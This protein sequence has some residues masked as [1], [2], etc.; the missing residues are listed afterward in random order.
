MDLISTEIEGMCLSAPA[1]QQII[2]TDNIPDS[3][4][5]EMDATNVMTGIMEIDLRCTHATMIFFR[6]RSRNGNRHNERQY[7]RAYNRDNKRQYYRNDS[8]DNENYNH[9]NSYNKECR[10]H[11]Y[12]N[13]SNERFV[14]IEHRLGYRDF[15]EDYTYYGG[16][17]NDHL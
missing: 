1:N 14:E 15:D 9:R 7:F 13:Y 3:R 8:R 11:N 5:T 10:G 16:K 12:S 4:T 2:G 17:R 6:Y